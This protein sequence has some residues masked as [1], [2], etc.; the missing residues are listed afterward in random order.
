MSAPMKS[1]LK[2]RLK[3][4]ANFFGLQPR[5]LRACLN[6][7]GT[8]SKILQQL[9][10]N[11]NGAG[12]GNRTLVFSLEVEEFPCRFNGHSDIF[13]ALRV[14]E[15]ITEFPVVGMATRSP[16]RGNRAP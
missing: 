9:V 15:T 7:V 2:S 12:E 3:T 8:W 4:L 16:A 14:I 1:N 5:R 11:A 6:S 10:E 13:A